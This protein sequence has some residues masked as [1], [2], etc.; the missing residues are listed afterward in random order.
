ML[1]GFHYGQVFGISNWLICQIL[2]R[3]LEVLLSFWGPKVKYSRLP[4][5]DR[6]SIV[7]SLQDSAM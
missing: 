5:V 2:Q 6:D 4:Y 3:Y 1:Q 7:D